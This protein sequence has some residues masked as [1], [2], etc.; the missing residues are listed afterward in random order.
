MRNIDFFNM[1]KS[2]HITGRTSTITNVFVCSVIPRMY[3]S[4][5]QLNKCLKIL[6]LTTEDLRCAYCGDKSTEWDHLRPIVEKKRPTGYISEIHNLVPACGKCNQSKGNKHWKKWM[7][8]KARYSPASR[9]V[10]NLEDKVKRLEEY[11]K[12]EGVTKLDF[13]NIVGEKIWKQHW[14]NCEKMHIMMRD[15][16]NLAEE[17]KGY[18]EAHL[19]SKP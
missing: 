17:V 19:K 1:P 15:A 5:E 4:E 7:L 6:N 12:W 14:D 8:G 2:T 11:E 13:E 16:Q 9:G 3:P 18:I 10:N